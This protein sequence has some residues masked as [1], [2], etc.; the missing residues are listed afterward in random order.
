MISIDALHKK[1]PQALAWSFGDSEKMADDLA[2]LV[3]RGTKTASCCSFH[4]FQADD[5]PPAIGSHN[6]ILD[7][8]GKPVCVIR[9]IVL[10]LIR[11]S[12]VTEELAVKEGEG[13][14]SLEYWRHEHRD[15]FTR[16]GT[17]SED[18]LLVAEEFEVVE[19]L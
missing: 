9:T 6:I 15:F 13:D 4:S 17:W 10:R 1:Y 12:D 19:I 2:Q 8:R 7:G 16:E 11:F 18:M 14:L 5:V 3:V